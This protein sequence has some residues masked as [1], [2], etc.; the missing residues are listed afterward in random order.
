V[1]LHR[2]DQGSGHPVVLLHAW[3]M[4][5]RAFA[6]LADRL[7]CAH[8]VISFDLRGHGRSPAPDDGYEIASLAQDVL[9][10]LGELGLASYDVLGWSLGSSVAVAM[11]GAPA[12]RIRSL[13]LVAPATPLLVP[14][15][16]FTAA[17]PAAM[18][19][20]IR[21]AEVGDQRAF[22]QSMI[23]RL[24]AKPLESVAVETLLEE[25]M[26]AG[27]HAVLATLESLV[28]TDQRR[29]LRSFDKPVWLAHGREDV[30]APFAKSEWIAAN[31]A[32]AHL[33]VFEQCGHAPFL[34]QPD[35]FAESMQGFLAAQER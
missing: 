30:F 4:S 5:G 17:A 23:A 24:T 1:D 29:E 8:R 35:Q 27:T 18:A 16:D 31:L 14:R 20:H 21:D 22:R 25:S 13:A 15:E 3:G 11:A 12:S 9:I 7:S 32:S 2:L 6:G 33:E 26:L 19:E 34:E 28:M 10:A